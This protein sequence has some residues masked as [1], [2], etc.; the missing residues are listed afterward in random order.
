MANTVICTNRLCGKEYHMDFKKCP[1]CGTENP[2]LYRINKK[3]EQHRIAVAQ[4]LEQEKKIEAESGGVYQSSFRL[5]M[6]GGHVNGIK[7]NIWADIPWFIFL[8]GGAALIGVVVLCSLASHQ[9]QSEWYIWGWITT[10]TTLVFFLSNVLYRCLLNKGFDAKAA[11]N[12]TPPPLGTWN[13]IGITCLGKYRVFG[14]TQ[15][16]YVFLSLFFPIIPIG[17][18]RVTESLSTTPHR[19]GPAWKSSTRYK[20]FGSEKWNL[21]E[22][23]HVYLSSYSIKILLLCAFWFIILLFGWT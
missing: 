15:V 19:D 3:E 23:L 18:Y 20:I 21:L 2:L 13:A 10:I 7:S 1:F 9:R 16:S 17:C 6:E 11:N 14:N 8:I 4:K 5:L 22:V 12:E